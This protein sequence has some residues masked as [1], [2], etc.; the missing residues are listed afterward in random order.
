MTTTDPRWARI[1]ALPKVELHCHFNGAIPVETYIALAAK[2]KEPLRTTDPRELYSYHDMPSFLAVYEHVSSLL[3]GPEDWSRAV[4]D[5]L[6][7]DR[8]ASNL[9]YREMFVNLTLDGHPPYAEVIAG[10]EDGITRARRDFG[11][12]AG[13]IP[14]IYRSQ[15]LEVAERMID[16]MLAQPNPLVVGIGMDGDENLG[17]AEQ[18]VPLYRRVQEAGLGTSAHSGERYSPDEVRYAMDVLKVDRVDHGYAIIKDP[19]LVREAR[20]R[21]THFASAWLSSISHYERDR[22]HNPLA[23]MI[24]AGLDVL[25]G[26]DDPAMAHSTL[27]AD[28]I[29]PA[30]AFGLSE[31]YLIEQNRRAL[32]ASWAPE[33]LRAR[34]A[35]E[36][37]TTTEGS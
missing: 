1:A 30:E 4:Y 22:D 8:M 28:L 35:A 26:S 3:R 19:G 37:A 18:F 34:L 32:R 31:G 23:A 6:R 17:P 16:D 33:D 20:D 36:I 5:S 12:D 25:L 2:Y 15:P 9:R 13:I 7:A 11:V 10:L 14:S 21:G 29:A 24:D 27:L